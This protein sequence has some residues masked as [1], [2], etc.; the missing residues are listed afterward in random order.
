M[1]YDKALKITEKVKLKEDDIFKPYSQEEAKKKGFIAP[2]P[3]DERTKDWQFFSTSWKEFSGDAVVDLQ[4]ILKKFGVH[5]Y[6]D[7]RCEGDADLVFILTKGN[8]NKRDL[9]AYLKGMFP[10][11]FE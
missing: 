1:S 2:K 11:D 8:F 4:K 5:M 6:E 3:P 7:P 9:I 10:E